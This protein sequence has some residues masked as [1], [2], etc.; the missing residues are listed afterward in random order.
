MQLKRNRI[1]L[2]GIADLKGLLDVLN[3]SVLDVQDN[4]ID[5]ES[6]VEEILM[7]MPNLSVLYMQNNP[8]CK[9]I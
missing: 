5:D 4:K 6:F 7:K 2:N 3:I 8:V 9:K 1:G